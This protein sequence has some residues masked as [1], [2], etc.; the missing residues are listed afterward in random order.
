MA[1]IRDNLDYIYFDTKAEAKAALKNIDEIAEAYER[2][3]L[4]DIKD[5]LD[6]DSEWSDTKVYWT[7]TAIR[8]HAM[9]GRMHGRWSIYMPLEYIDNRNKAVKV[10]YRD[11]RYK[12]VESEDSDEV[13]PVNPVYINI[14]TS[15]MDDPTGILN[16]VFSNLENIRDRDVFINVY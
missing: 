12:R 16:D 11:Y 3:S 6:M 10:S 2:V 4:S 7:K 14:T 9:V 1:Y 8:M 15:D 13:K 5:L